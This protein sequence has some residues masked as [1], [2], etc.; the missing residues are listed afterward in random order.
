MYTLAVGTARGEVLTF[1][2]FGTSEYFL[3]LAVARDQSTHSAWAEV[4]AAN[5]EVRVRYRG[6]HVTSDSPEW[7]WQDDQLS[8]RRHL[9]S[10]G[11]LSLNPPGARQQ[12]AY[13]Q[14]DDEEDV[15]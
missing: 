4:R 14:D 9:V 11:R 2:V 3:A 12:P 15:W 10:L 1:P 13:V 6:G 7:A 5:G 8:H